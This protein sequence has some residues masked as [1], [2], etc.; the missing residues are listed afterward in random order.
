MDNVQQPHDLPTSRFIPTEQITD[1]DIR[2]VVGELIE[3]TGRTSFYGIVCDNA[4][5]DLDEFEIITD[6]APRQFCRGGWIKGDGWE[7]RLIDADD[8]I[9]YVPLDVV[10]DF[11][12]EQGLYLFPIEHRPEAN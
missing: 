2:R 8:P 12:T 9:V 4:W 10:E 11:E 7:V 3:A 1:D 6:Y 5:W